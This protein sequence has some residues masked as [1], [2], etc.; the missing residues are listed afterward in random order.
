[1]KR[2]IFA[3]EDNDALDEIVSNIK[4]DFDY[5]MDGIETLNRRGAD[6]AKQAMSIA[7]NISSDLEQHIA[8][9]ANSITQ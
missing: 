6:S 7:T 8:A 9:V 4:A 5:I 2:K 3:A 1:M